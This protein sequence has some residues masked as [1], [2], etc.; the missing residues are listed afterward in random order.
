MKQ[1]TYANRIDLLWNLFVPK[2]H[3]IVAGGGKEKK[4]FG[5]AFWGKQYNNETEDGI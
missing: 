5:I 2:F 3:K 4:N 1:L